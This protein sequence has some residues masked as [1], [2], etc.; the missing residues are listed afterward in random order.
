MVHM[1][2]GHKIYANKI[3]AFKWFLIEWQMLHNSKRYDTYVSKKSQNWSQNYKKYIHEDI[4]IETK[5]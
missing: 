4:K 3:Y 2:Y 5:I 1:Y